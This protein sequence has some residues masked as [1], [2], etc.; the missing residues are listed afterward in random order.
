MQPLNSGLTNDSGSNIENFE[1]RRGGVPRGLHMRITHEKTEISR[2]CHRWIEIFTLC[3][4]TLGICASEVYSATTAVL[5]DIGFDNGPAE[6]LIFDDIDQT[7][8]NLIPGMGE[9]SLQTAPASAPVE[10]AIYLTG[11]IDMESDMDMLP[12]PTVTPEPTLEISPT[13]TDTTLTPTPAPSFTPAPGCEQSGVELSMPRNNYRPGDLCWLNALV[14]NSAQATLENVQVFVV[15][16]IGT[17]EYWF[18]PAWAY[19][20]PDIDSYAFDLPPGLLTIHVVREFTWPADAGDHGPY[21]FWGAITDG[22]VTE[23]IGNLGQF[24]FQYH[25]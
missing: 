18:A 5:I 20:P 22:E 1:L 21:W 9:L 24:E 3:A 25:S 8:R 10:N 11:L 4:A 6:V 13:P 17:G 12:Y 19:Y 7:S 15:L 2:C 23:I 16:D 14:C